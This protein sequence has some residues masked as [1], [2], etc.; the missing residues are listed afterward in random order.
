MPPFNKAGEGDLVIPEI[1]ETDKD[2][3]DI[4]KHLRH[5]HERKKIQIK[6]FN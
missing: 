3:Y 1:K 2:Y 4:S 5:Q 6:E